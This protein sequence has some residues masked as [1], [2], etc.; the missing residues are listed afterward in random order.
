MGID[1]TL[2]VNI[3]IVPDW[4]GGLSLAVPTMFA[5]LDVPN[6]AQRSAN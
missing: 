3:A 2:R 6:S 1:P 4:V 5:V